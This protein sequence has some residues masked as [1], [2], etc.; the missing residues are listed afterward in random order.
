MT[1][2]TLT[3]LGN[4]RDAIVGIREVLAT[5]DLQAAVPACPGW[6]LHDL[7]GHLGNVHRWVRGAIVEG[8]PNTPPEAPPTGREPL[9]A[10]YDEG[11]GGL[12]D[13]LAATD[14]GAPCW[15]FGPAPKIAAFWFRRQA[16]EH[17]V[18]AHDAAASQGTRRPIETALAL[19]G[20]DEV[21]RMFL[22]RQVRLG[23]IE[24]LTRSLEVRPDE[25][26]GTSWLL[27]GD[28]DGAGA[29]GADAGAVVAGPAEAL[30]L[31]LWRRVGLGDP[32]LA[33]TGDRSAAEAVLGTPIVP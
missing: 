3:R 7:A 16:H 9:L 28:G 23:R 15:T 19:D 10:W 4:V 14:P 1:V 12:L 33:V 30:Y 17:A 20:I 6:T 25:S 21:V 22:P 8:H 32:R 29:D 2:E 26:G 11:A 27:R 18:H 31:L 5:G 24:P 13:L